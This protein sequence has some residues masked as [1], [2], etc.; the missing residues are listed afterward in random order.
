MIVSVMMMHEMKT[1]IINIS[2]IRSCYFPFNLENLAHTSENSAEH[3]TDP[4][5]YLA[6][7]S[8]TL[9]NAL[10]SAPMGYV[11]R[12]V[13]NGPREVVVPSAEVKDGHA[14]FQE[15]Q[16]WLTKKQPSPEE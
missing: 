9:G 10:H 8:G 11:A 1:N 4:G 13:V 16:E 2:G 15:Y 3:R 5:R 14:W 12:K 7:E 6:P